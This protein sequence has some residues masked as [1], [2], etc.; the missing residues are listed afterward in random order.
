MTS[1]APRNFT[2][3]VDFE[4]LASRSN[5]FGM[6]S[7]SPSLFKLSSRRVLTF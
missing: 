2:I 7:G 3:I 4:E 6:S 1:I 5:E